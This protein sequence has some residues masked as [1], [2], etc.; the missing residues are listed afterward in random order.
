MNWQ[1]WVTGLIGAAVFAAVIFRV[2]RFIKGANDPCRGCDC[3]CARSYKPKS[4]SDCA[5]NTRKNI[6]TG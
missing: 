2:V 6:T 5:N 1:Y 3:D 4:M